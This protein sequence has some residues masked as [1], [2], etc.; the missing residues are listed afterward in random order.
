[1]ADDPA[2]TAAMVGVSD[3][4]VAALEAVVGDVTAERA[5]VE[6]AL[7]DY[8]ATRRAHRISP[9]DEFQA[10]FFLS[11]PI[12]DATGIALRS[13]AIDELG[14]DHAATQRITALFAYLLG[15]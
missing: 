13:P 11:D 15:I 2:Y 4:F 5:A 1:M 12:I 9:E 14:F 7:A 6:H 10:H 3:R 8:C